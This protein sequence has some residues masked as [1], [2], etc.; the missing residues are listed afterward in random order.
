MQID[1]GV[2]TGARC[3]VGAEGAEIERNEV[4][5]ARAQT[6]VFETGRR[7]IGATSD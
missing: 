6:M 4:E 2:S 5:I 3:S 1:E 7:Q